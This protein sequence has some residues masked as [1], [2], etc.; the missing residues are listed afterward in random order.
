MFERCYYID[1]A[2]PKSGA[3]HFVLFVCLLLAVI[4]L[5]K[6][7][8]SSRQI[9][10]K[11]EKKKEK[12]KIPNLAESRTRVVGVWSRILVHLAMSVLWHFLS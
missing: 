10:K 2:K 5:W 3:T 11:K 1:L 8:H 6:Y 12:K 7:S 9:K 4:N